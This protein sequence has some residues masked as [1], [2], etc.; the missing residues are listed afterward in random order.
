[1]FQ[2]TIHMV[3]EITLSVTFL[4]TVARLSLTKL[5]AAKTL[6][7]VLSLQLSKRLTLMC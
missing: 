4:N 1:M 7:S 6:T 5:I 3:S 2:A